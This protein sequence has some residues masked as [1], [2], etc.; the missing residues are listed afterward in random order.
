L[1]YLSATLILRPP[2]SAL[3]PPHVMAGLDP[4]LHA[5]RA[6]PGTPA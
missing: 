3:R 1:V 4:A 5:L 6:A 2:P